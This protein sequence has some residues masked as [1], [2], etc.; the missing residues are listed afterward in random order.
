MRTYMYVVLDCLRYLIGLVLIL[1]QR[2]IDEAVHD[3]LS[4]FYESVSAVING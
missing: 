4:R 3:A 2:S 1:Q